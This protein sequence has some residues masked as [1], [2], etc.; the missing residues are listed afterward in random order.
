MKKVIFWSLCI[1]SVASMENAVEVE[2]PQAGTHTIHN[3]QVVEKEIGEY[4]KL[5]EG[6]KED[7]S[8]LGVMLKAHYT[9]HLANLQKLLA[10]GEISKD[11]EGQLYQLHQTDSLF[12]RYY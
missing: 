5:L 6:V 4:T 2:L 7:N 12:S 8:P 9:D 1:T 10:S 11:I 3:T